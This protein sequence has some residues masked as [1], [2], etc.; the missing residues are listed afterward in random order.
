MAKGLWN[1]KLK[2]DDFHVP[3]EVLEQTAD[4]RDFACILKNNRQREL[5]WC[6]ICV[7]VRSHSYT[8]NATSCTNDVSFVAYDGNTADFH[9][10]M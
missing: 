8:S 7:S 3:D 10:I 9:C 5:R 4:L 1:G 2:K 6:H